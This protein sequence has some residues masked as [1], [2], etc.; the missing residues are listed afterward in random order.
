MS[1]TGTRG[2][3]AEG[4]VKAVLKKMES[5]NCAHLRFPDA[6]AGSLATAPADFMF[7]KN[8]KLTLLEV[9]EVNHAHRLPYQNFALDQIARLRLWQAA[10]AA[11]WVLVYFTPTKEW[12]YEG[13][14]EFM[15]RKLVSETGRPIGSWNL[16]HIPSQTLDQIFLEIT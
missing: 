9:K 10:G 6:R 15:D 11:A 7:L 3:F 2:K 13:L 1:T 12:K 5:A 16:S 14:L 8:G 4:K